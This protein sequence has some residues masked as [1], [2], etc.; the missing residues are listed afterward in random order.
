MI[1]AHGACGYVVSNLIGRIE[2]AASDSLWSGAA[3]R[4]GG[5]G[6]VLNVRASREATTFVNFAMMSKSKP[7]PDPG[8]HT[9]GGPSLLSS[10][11]S[12]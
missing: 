2:N 11:S 7:S 4:G 5:D 9:V 8:Y 3:M 6:Y 1:V 12:S 10:L